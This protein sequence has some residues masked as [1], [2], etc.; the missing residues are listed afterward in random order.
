MKIKTIDIALVLIYLLAFQNPLEKYIVLFSYIDEI[1]GIMGPIY[2]CVALIKNKS[3]R[4]K[5]SIIK[6]SLPLIVFVI[7]GLISN[8]VYQYQPVKLVLVDLYTNLKFYLAIISGVLIFSGIINNKKNQRRMLV[9]FK[10]ISLI[11]GI[12]F[13][14]DRIYPIFPVSEVRYG[15]RSAM[16]FFEH[17]T[18]LAGTFIF[19]IAGLTAF[20]ERGVEKYI[21]GNLIVLCFTLR[22]KA[23]GAAI[24][25][26]M[27]WF[28]TMFLRKKIKWWHIAVIGGLGLILG[29]QQINYYYFS[30]E[31]KS[32][33][34]VL[35]ITS[36]K[37]AKEYFPLGVG[38]ASYASHVAGE[39]YSPVYVKYGFE[40]IYE[41]ARYNK[42][43]FF[44][45]TFW[46]IIL[47]Q[48][49]VIGFIAYIF[50]LK[51]LIKDILRLKKADKRI[52]TSAIFIMCYLL[53]SSTSEPAFNNSI[54]V[55]LGFLLGI[56]FTIKKKRENGDKTIC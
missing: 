1:I 23:I 35:T 43:A 31:G 48:T 39:F 24:I 45:D 32:A 25:Y 18:Y 22:S 3:I 42:N 11:I 6:K 28:V 44:D 36:L 54:A 7:M 21:I 40:R 47:G 34:S 20:Y 9:H 56:F 19:I 10:I 17:P 41:L 49:G 4:I 14:V 50:V 37:I 8:Y 29:W 13:L 46:P 52:Y 26:V 2:I 5:K 30:L 38:F 12:S 33:R 55:P 16:L 53:I 51:N 15:I 27:I